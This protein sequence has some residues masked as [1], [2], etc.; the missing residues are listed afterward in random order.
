MGPTH[1]I[2]VRDAPPNSLAKVVISD[3]PAMPYDS[4]AFPPLQPNPLPPISIYFEQ[5][6]PQGLI[7]FCLWPHFEELPDGKQSYIPRFTVDPVPPVGGP[8]SEYEQEFKEAPKFYAMQTCHLSEPH[9]AHVLPGG[10]RAVYYTT[11]YDDRT[12]APSMIRLRRYISPE[13]QKVVYPQRPEDNSLALCRKRRPFHPDGLYGTIDIPLEDANAFKKGINAITW[14]ESIG[15]ICIAVEGELSVRILDMARSVEP[16]GRFSGWMERMS[17]EMVEQDCWTSKDCIHSQS[18]P[19][20]YEQ[21]IN[22]S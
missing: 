2:V 8:T 14:D 5:R 19:G 21:W 16:D 18:V 15:R 10:Y 7:H 20:W 6:Q 1:H 9:V 13:I 17:Y 4:N 22:S 3:P 12:A 11:S